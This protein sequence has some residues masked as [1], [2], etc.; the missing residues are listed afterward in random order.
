M[1]FATLALLGAVSAQDMLDAEV[2]EM[3]K[4]VYPWAAVKDYAKQG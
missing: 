2:E 3:I 4:V 1:K